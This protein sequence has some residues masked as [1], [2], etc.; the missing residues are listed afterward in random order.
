MFRLKLAVSRSIGSAR[1][2]MR[3]V[4]KYPTNN[5]AHLADLPLNW[6]TR[7]AHY[8][9][10]HLGVKCIPASI[11]EFPLPANDAFVAL[12]EARLLVLLLPLGDCYFAKLDF[13]PH[14]LR[15]KLSLFYAWKKTGLCSPLAVNKLS[16]LLLLL[17][18]L[19][20]TFDA[21]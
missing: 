16:P 5:M 3:L 21:A 8:M 14:F 19:F 4:G 18:T 20:S 13:F 12:V 10:A 6:P 2:I 15:G 1:N 11:I 17:L 7:G 9:R